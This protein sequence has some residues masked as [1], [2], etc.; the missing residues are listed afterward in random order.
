MNPT[1]DRDCSTPDSRRHEVRRLQWL[2]EW[3]SQQTAADWPRSDGLQV[4]R[5]HAHQPSELQGCIAVAAAAADKFALAMMIRIGC[6]QELINAL[7]ALLTDAFSAFPRH[8]T[9]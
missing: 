6:R 8:V 4:A 9:S 5:L 7:S 3:H 2:V 1:D